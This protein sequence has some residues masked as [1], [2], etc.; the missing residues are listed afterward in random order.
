MTNPNK[1]SNNNELSNED[2]PWI[3]MAET[4]QAKRL[5]NNGTETPP[6]PE[7]SEDNNTEASLPPNQTMDAPTPTEPESPREPEELRTETSPENST[8]SNLTPEEIDILN[9]KLEENPVNRPV[10]GENGPIDLYNPDPADLQTVKDFIHDNE[11][12]QNERYQKELRD[13]VKNTLAYY[14][15]KLYEKTPVPP[16]EQHEL[17]I[18]FNVYSQALSGLSHPDHGQTTVNQVFTAIEKKYSDLAQQLEETKNLIIGSED[19]IQN[20]QLAAITAGRAAEK[21]PDLPAESKE[22]EESEESK[23]TEPNSLELP[24]DV[25]Y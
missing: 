14:E 13:D 6:S 7:R 10:I 18:Q 3:A 23:N 20:L 9:K 22:S 2:N 8:Q 15:K 1:I 25:M 5:K 4:V 16:D 19:V 21:Y 11:V 24:G 12:D 17:Q